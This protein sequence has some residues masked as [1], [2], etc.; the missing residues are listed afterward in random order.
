MELD[1]KERLQYSVGG[2]L[3]APSTGKNVPGKIRDGAFKNLTSMAFCLEDAVR[4]ESLKEAEESLGGI[5]RELA[6]IRERLPLL[7][8]RI[9]TPEHM[10]HI[11]D[12]Y[13]EYRH[14]ITGYI[15]PKFDLSNMEEY[16]RL[17]TDINGENKER[18]TYIMPILESR[19]VAD[20]ATR[21]GALQKIKEALDTVKGYVLNVRVGGNDF[22]NLYGLRRAENQSIYDIGVIRDILADIVNVFASDYVVSGPVWEYFGAQ[23][24]GR[25]DTGLIREMELD[26]LNGLIG[27]TAIHP[28]QLP[29][30][31]EGMKVK[32]PD[33]DDAM[34][35]L[36][37]QDE[38]AVAKSVNG[39]RMNEVKVHGKWARKIAILGS[40]Y[41]IKEG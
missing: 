20:L 27:K 26:R 6:G 1:E 35:I 30:I 32:R 22:C 18:V 39:A 34:K 41:G 14:I 17:V 21:I 2:L 25:W 29:V 24:D 19:M 36:N 16:R 13:R 38:S 9:R 31:F 11:Y 10:R 4:D 3:Y 40:I 23:R 15:L 37:W 7:F 12:L 33:Y 28:S 8:I 5:L